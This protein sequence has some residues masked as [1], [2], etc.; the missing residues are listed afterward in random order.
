[1]EVRI[2]PTQPIKGFM[3]FEKIIKKGFLNRST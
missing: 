2:P 1:V 3:H